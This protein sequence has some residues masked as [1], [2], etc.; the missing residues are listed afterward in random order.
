MGRKKS[1]QPERISG[2]YAA[3][4]HALLDSVA[5]QGASYTAKALLCELMR[6]HN[7]RNNGHLQLTMSW[8]ARRNWTS[9]DV[10][11]RAKNELIDRRLIIETRKGGFNIGPSLFAVTWLTISNFSGLDLLRNEYHPGAWTR[12]DKPAI[13]NAFAIPPAGLDRSEIR[14]DAAPANGVDRTAPT[15]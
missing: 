7:G 12:M 4:P 10:V 5:F 8:L 13:K 1:E 3:I 6:Q 2:L 14:S 9:C 11:Q 15:P